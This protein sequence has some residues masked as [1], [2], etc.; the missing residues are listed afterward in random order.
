M[1]CELMMCP[2]NLTLWVLNWH[3]SRLIVMPAYSRRLSTASSLE[4]CS[5]WSLCMLHSTCSNPWRIWFMFFW[6]FSEPE[7]TPKGKTL[8][9][10]CLHDI[11]KVVS[12]PNSNVSFI[13]QNPEFASSL[14]KILDPANLPSVV[15]T[16]GRGWYS[17]FTYLFSLLRSTHIL[18][19]PLLLGVTT[20]GAHQS[21][22]WST[23]AMTPD[24]SILSNSSLVF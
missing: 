24:S 15:S 18:T 23:L 9:Q 11:M 16:A 7:L 17:L 8:K 4:L 6:N 10:K 13:C 14:V 21:V 12:S 3:F 20:M 19:F 5:S 22:D 1:P 2:R